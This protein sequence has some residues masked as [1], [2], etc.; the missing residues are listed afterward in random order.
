MNY[1]RKLGGQC[2]NRPTVIIGNA[3]PWDFEYHVDR[4]NLAFREKDLHGEIKHDIP[5]FFST[6]EYCIFLPPDAAYEN[7][8]LAEWQRKG[9]AMKMDAKLYR[10]LFARY[11]VRSGLASGTIDVGG[12]SFSLFNVN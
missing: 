10:T 2:E 4:E 6:G 1:L 12:V 7:A 11:D 5:A 9:Y 3:W 8:L